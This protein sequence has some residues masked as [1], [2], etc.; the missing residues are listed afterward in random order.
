MITRLILDGKTIRVIDGLFDPV[1]VFD[2]L[3]KGQYLE[4]ENKQLDLDKKEFRIYLGVYGAAVK[5]VIKAV[6]SQV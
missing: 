5:A 3:H 6:N 2:I 1:G 4:V